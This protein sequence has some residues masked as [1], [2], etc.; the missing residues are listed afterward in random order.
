M[1]VGSANYWTVKPTA[2]RAAEHKKYAKKATQIFA[3]F[4]FFTNIKDVL[5]YFRLN[6]TLINSFILELQNDS[7]LMIIN[8]IERN[9]KQVTVKLYI[10]Y[11]YCDYISIFDNWGK[12]M[13]SMKATYR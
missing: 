3:I 6:W 12:L 7:P 13:H 2:S 1:S 8:E 10:C 5:R 9:Y 11:F 4:A